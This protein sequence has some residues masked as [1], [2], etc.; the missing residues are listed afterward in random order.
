M[1]VGICVGR[2]KV[3]I[4]GWGIMYECDTGGGLMLFH[5]KFDIFII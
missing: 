4:W 5:I 3:D 1:S 2:G